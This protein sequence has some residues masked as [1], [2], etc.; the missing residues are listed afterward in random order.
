MV[1]VSPVKTEKTKTS[2]SK[3]ASIRGQLLRVA[4][5]LSLCG[6][7]VAGG[8]VFYLD[9]RITDWFE[10]RRWALPAKVFSRPVELY[11]G[12]AIALDELLYELEH[13]E[14]VQNS[15]YGRPGNSACVVTD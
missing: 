1:K 14:Y 12:Q 7:V 6:L 11:R 5:L 8:W 4:F 15:R 9:Q 10:G 13:Q 2:Q 3:A